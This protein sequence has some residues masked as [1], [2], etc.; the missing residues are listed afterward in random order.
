M[1]VNLRAKYFKE[2]AKALEAI[3]KGIVNECN[4]KFE[5]N[6]KS[7]WKL[8]INEKKFKE[9]IENLSQ[10]LDHMKNLHN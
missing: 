8:Q 9:K 5:D 3:V 2:A 1:S 4:I 10:L 7:M 6:K